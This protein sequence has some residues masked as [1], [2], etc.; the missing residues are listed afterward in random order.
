METN[1]VDGQVQ[2]DLRAGSGLLLIGGANLRYTN[3]DSDNAIPKNLV[4]IRG[5]GFVHAQWQPFG[6][7]QLCGGL[8]LDLNNKTQEALSPR[9][10]VVYR[11][12][13]NH[14]FR[15][16]YGLAF[17]KP[18]FIESS[19]HFE[20][21]DY[22]PAFPEVVDKL[23]E[24]LG[25]EDLVNEKVHSFEAGWRAYL[26]DDRLE[27]AA[28]LFTN[29]YQDNIYFH[30][31]MPT[32][33]GGV[34]DIPNSVLQFRNQASDI[35]AFGGELHSSWAQSRDLTLWG[36][37]G[38]RMVV[39][40][41]SGERLPAEPVLRV[42]L[43]CRWSP[44]E[45]WILDLALHYVSARQTLLL[46][47]QEPLEEYPVHRLEQALLL[48]GRFGHRWTLQERQLEAGLTVRS[49]LGLPFREFAGVPFPDSLQSEV[50]SD[51]GGEEIVRWISLYLRGSF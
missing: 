9:A 4:E 15:L 31:Y 50:D 41:D 23:K 19:M 18:A 2:L 22:N 34:P 16:G 46:D 13:D 43:G 47:P 5:A 49:P 48:L 45:G 11:P 14:S 20:V 28:D 29:I 42:N 44:E 21:L 40:A 35:L 32:R 17:R 38:L 30:S 8:R 10:V 37:L 24:S 7:L 33:L 26:F 51:F 25:N 39:D 27:L 12:L 1:T 3:M 36:N 6:V